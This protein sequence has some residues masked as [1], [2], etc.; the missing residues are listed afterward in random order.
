[1]K[2]ALL[3]ILPGLW[4]AAP[5]AHAQT[6][7]P[8]QVK[9]R[10]EANLPA[11]D[12]LKKTGKVGEANNGY[13]KARVALSEAEERLLKTENTDRK[14]VYQALAERAKTTL[15]KMEQARAEQIRKRSAPGVWL[16][17][18]AGEWYQKQE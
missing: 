3:L 2:I 12:K 15:E 18:P 6:P 17:N 4:L 13:L 1:M 16:Q 9:A 5:A 11:V 14:Y 7:T 8:E 10:M